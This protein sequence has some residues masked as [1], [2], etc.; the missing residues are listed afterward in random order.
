MAELRH[1][2]WLPAA[3]PA[4]PALIDLRCS[5]DFNE[6]WVRG[7]AEEASDSVGEAFI[8]SG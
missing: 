6:V 7:R 3:L 4:L 1:R 2:G 5:M 8:E